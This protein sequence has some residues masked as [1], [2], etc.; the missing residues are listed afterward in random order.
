M[1]ITD[2]LQKVGAENVEIQSVQASLVSANGKKDHSQ[3]TIGTTAITA[4]D[5]LNHKWP[6]IGIIVWVD[7]DKYEQA[8][9]S[10]TP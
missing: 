6:K 9:K 7:R 2:L 4:A 10:L 5:L 3:I 8:K 1:S